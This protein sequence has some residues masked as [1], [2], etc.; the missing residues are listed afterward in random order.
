MIILDKKHQPGKPQI[1]DENE[2]LTA[3]FRQLAV[4]TGVDNDIVWTEHLNRYVTNPATMEG[5]TPLY[6]Q[7]TRGNVKKELVKDNMTVSNFNHGMQFLDI[8]SYSLQIVAVKDGV[9][10]EGLVQVGNGNKRLRPVR[11]NT[12]KEFDFNSMA[13]ECDEKKDDI[14][15]SLVEKIIVNKDNNELLD[16]TVKDYY[17]QNLPDGITPADAD[18]INDYNKQIVDNVSIAVV[19]ANETTRGTSISSMTVPITP[20]EASITVASG[21]RN[22]TPSVTVVRPSEFKSLDEAIKLTQSLIRKISK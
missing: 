15:M 8:D 7:Q 6:Q 17:Y 18:R 19:A 12:N 9:I 10:H 5:A 16:A 11:V 14:I 4:A 1:A 13:I 3:L 2:V 22:K 21:G 20:I